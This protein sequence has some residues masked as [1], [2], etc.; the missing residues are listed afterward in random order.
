MSILSLR[1]A[2]RLRVLATFAVVFASC[3]ACS[4][5]EVDSAAVPQ[6]AQYCVYR[7]CQ[8]YGIACDISH[9]CQ[10]MPPKPKGESLLEMK[11][12]FGLIGLGATGVRLGVLDES[13]FR[14]LPRPFIAS[15]NGHFIV[16]DDF[17]EDAV[18]VFDGDG[19]RRIAS[20]ADIM[21]RWDGNA[22]LVSKPE[23]DALLPKFLGRSTKGGPAIHITTLYR[24]VGDLAVEGQSDVDFEFVVWNRG[25]E[26]LHIQD[27]VTSCQCSIPQRITEPIVPGESREL[28]VRYHISPAAGPFEH[29]VTIQSNDVAVPFVELSIAGNP[30]QKLV[31]S[32]K[33]IEFKNVVK[34]QDVSKH[35]YVRYTGDEILEL[36]PHDSGLL[37]VGVVRIDESTLKGEWDRL[38]KEFP[39]MVI[40]DRAFEGVNKWIVE[41]R[42]GQS[43]HDVVQSTGTVTVGTNLPNRPILELPYSIQFVDKVRCFP[44]S[45]FLGEIAVDGSSFVEKTITIVPQVKGDYTLKTVTMRGMR[46]L[47]YACEA[48]KD[49]NLCVKISGYALA[50]YSAELPCLTI[51]LMTFGGS[52]D[53]LELELP[54]VY[55]KLDAAAGY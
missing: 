2:C 41:V 48:D 30:V 49:G 22:L 4:R 51:E 50:E 35:V 44:S 14:K 16:V 18:T 29:R 43:A 40:V 45:L 53:P 21:R 15:L 26:D 25:S 46:Q 10:L 37:S 8:L 33:T 31:T 42:V 47:D 19:R 23:P 52:G 32:H 39:Q 34:G 27:M 36:S 20:V 1:G 11:S 17:D 5:R 7:I 24:D 3:M 13:E 9:I 54:I 38:T 28:I 12:M 55:Q 6:C